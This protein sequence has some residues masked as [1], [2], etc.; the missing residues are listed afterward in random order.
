MDSKPSQNLRIESVLKKK[1]NKTIYGNMAIL[2]DLLEEEATI[3]ETH[4]LAS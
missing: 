2:K 3:I 4:L 1:M